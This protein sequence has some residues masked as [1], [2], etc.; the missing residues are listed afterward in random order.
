MNSSRYN[1]RNIDRRQFDVVVGATNNKQVVV[2]A[3]LGSLFETTY[4]VGSELPKDAN[5]VVQIS[6]KKVGLQVG[7]DGI[8]QVYVNAR[9]PKN[10]GKLIQKIAMKE[11]KLLPINWFGLKTSTR[12]RTWSSLIYRSISWQSAIHTFSSIRIVKS[13]NGSATREKF[14]AA[15]RTFKI[16][17]SKTKE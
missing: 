6:E 15:F 5:E 2:D 3:D 10:M 14:L 8:D 4:D 7:F 11:A 17:E 1:V 12:D 9:T 16:H 13:K